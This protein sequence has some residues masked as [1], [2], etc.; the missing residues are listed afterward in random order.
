MKKAKRVFLA[1]LA[2]AFVF[3]IK[4][5]ADSAAYN[6]S[7]YIS[8]FNIGGILVNNASYG[9]VNLQGATDFSAVPFEV[10]TSNIPRSLF[11]VHSDDNVVIQNAQVD[12]SLSGSSGIAAVLSEGAVMYI[13]YGT[14]L[15]YSVQP[16]QVKIMRGGSYVDITNNGFSAADLAADLVQLSYNF[17]LPS[18]SLTNQN[19]NFLFSFSG[20]QST[21]PQNSVSVNIGNLTIVANVTENTDYTQDIYDMMNDPDTTG[22]NN[23]YDASFGGLSDQIGN[24]S[25]NFLSSIQGALNQISILT[26]IVGTEIGTFFNLAVSPF[27]SMV[28]TIGGAQIDIGLILIALA[29][30]S[31]VIY[32]IRLI[33]ALS[34]KNGGDKD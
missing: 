10:K 1:A 14:Q 19:F 16:L 26:N 22:L 34:E 8:G 31:F 17:S 20:G 15:L 27:T 30:I 23:G 21:A 13:R 32:I 12:I 6:A 7:S 24:T 11:A 3:A 33:F 28:F 18:F 25:Q 4:P 2:L 29:S 9:T 5:L